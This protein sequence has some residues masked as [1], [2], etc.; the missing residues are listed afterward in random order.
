[1]LLQMTLFHF[2]MANSPLYK[3]NIP[4]LLYPFICWWIF[5]WLPC[6]EVAQSCPALC[7]PVDCNLPDSSIHGILQ[8]RILEWVAI[9]FSRG[10]SQPR[11][12]TRVSRLAG[13]CFNLWATRET[14]QCTLGCMDLFE[15]YFSLN[16]CLEVWMWNQM[17]QMKLYTKQ[18]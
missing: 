15:L 6:L 1:M 12:W 10:S 3:M 13:R 18:K 16:I 7:D 9:S 8:A 2:F 11:D 5:R 17:T 4:H 14:L